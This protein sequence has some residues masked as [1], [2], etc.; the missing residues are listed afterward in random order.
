[1]MTLRCA[2][3]RPP[4]LPSRGAGPARGRA[5]PRGSAADQAARGRD[6]AGRR[7]ALGRSGKTRS[8]AGEGDQAAH[9][10]FQA[11]VSGQARSVAE[12]ATVEGVSDRYLSLVLP[13]AFLAPD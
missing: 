9:R 2:A 13:L 12:L 10:C 4:A 7:G 6:A 1:M 5:D 3:G 8:G 11:L